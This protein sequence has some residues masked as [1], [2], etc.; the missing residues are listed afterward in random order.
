MIT[1]HQSSLNDLLS[2]ANEYFRYM[3]R[4]FPVMCLSDEFYFFPRAEEAAYHLNKLEFFERDIIVE[5]NRKVGQWLGDLDRIGEGMDEAGARLL[6][7]SMAGFLREFDIRKVWRDDPTLYLK[8]SLI[9]L[10][11]LI[12]LESQGQKLERDWVRDRLR[13]IPKLLAS[14]KK[15]ILRVSLP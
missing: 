12:S 7:Q 3:G 4:T 14:G 1:N 5:A 11:Q 13:S 15:N 10:D 8:V 6:K 2:I 9:G